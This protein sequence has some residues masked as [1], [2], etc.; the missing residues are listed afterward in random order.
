MFRVFIRKN[1]TSMAIV[2][3][4][5]LFLIIQ[6]MK[7]SFIYNADG[8]FRHFGIGYKNKTVIPIWLVTILVAILSYVFILYYITLPRYRF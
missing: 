2:L 1:I 8:S 7:P 6:A 5:A 3:F 4:L